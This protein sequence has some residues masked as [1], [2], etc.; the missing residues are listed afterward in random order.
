MFS[1][2][3][4]GP[5]VTPGNARPAVT[6]FAQQL[7]DGAESRLPVELRPLAE[8]HWRAFREHLPRLPHDGT[9]TWLAAL[10]KLFAC[11]DFVARTCAQHPDLLGELIESRD[12]LRAYETGELTRR[13]ARALTGAPDE[14]ALKMRLRQLR[15]REMLR[16]AIRDLAGWA[17]LP[18]VLVTLSELADSCIDAA[19][20]WLSHG[21]QEEFG[22]P[23]G[24]DGAPVGLVVLG[25]GKLGGHELNFSSDV[26]LILTYSE[27]GETSGGRRSLSHGEFFVRL[28]QSL[29]RV[30]SEPTAD[31]FVFRVDT[32]LRPFGSSGPLALSFDAMEHYYQAHGREWERYALIKARAS[33]GDR[34]AGEELLARLRPFVYRRYLDYGA[35]EAIRGMKEMI[36]REVERK[37]MAD[38]VKLGP[39]GIREIEFIAQALQLIRGGR[40]PAL[41]ERTTLKALSLLAAA[42]H[43]EQAAVQTLSKAYHF[44]RRTEHCIQMIADQQTHNLPREPLDRARVAIAMGFADWE[45]FHAA[46]ARERALVQSQ[47]TGLLG[48]V[49]KP[50]NETDAFAVLWSGGMDKDHAVPILAHAGYQDAERVYAF[51]SELRESSA[52]QA[53]STEGRA[54]V[55]KFIP[56]LLRET[57]SAPEPDV[58]I[59]RLIQLCEAIGR[60]TAYFSLLIE[61]P[62]ALTQLINLAAASPWIAGWISQHPVLLD[63]LLDPRGLYELPDRTVLEA[64]LKAR[65]ESLAPDDLEAQMEVMREFRHAH[66][67]RIAAADIGP[68]LPSDQVG[69]RL[70]QLAE[71]LIAACLDL[72]F[73]LMTERHGSPGATAQSPAPGFVV[74][75]YGKLGSLEL[76]YA[77]DLDMIFLYDE[78]EGG[79]TTGARPIPNELF[80]ARLGQRLINLLTTRTPAGILYQVDMRLRPSGNAGPLVTSLTA[81][82]RYQ[83]NQAWT[84]EHQALVRAR[85]IAGAPSLRDAFETA[86]R[87]VLSRHRDE[88]ALRAEVKDMRNRMA[89]AHPPQEDGFDVKHD[90]GGIVDI[91]FMVQYWV[92]AWA[93]AHPDVT[94]PRDNIHIME[95]LATRGLIPRDWADALAQ[96]YRRC[97]SVE[98]RLKLMERG[99]RVPRA[100]FESTAATVLTIWNEI[101]ERE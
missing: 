9:E 7:F 44:L 89:A 6:D 51:L 4:I 39:G 5:I 16:I 66:M 31:G 19:L 85:P 12:L 56:L 35:L 91:E 40:E 95:A 49:E 63:E 75:G 27:E 57:A 82:Q 53:L 64:E 45:S 25:L 42:E 90:R 72:S 62:H 98:Q 46:L 50:A 21:M 71:V 2:K 96:A 1:A 14:H 99:A 8:A 92:L 43:L 65:L 87:E 48:M 81:F 88:S 47:F 58:T 100:E 83:Q 23:R 33:A 30:L 67:L 74:I 11:S 73:R 20:A 101:F 59:S 32:R 28:S 37:S 18:E 94:Q 36:A 61:N 17:D 77:S 80:F 84:W 15:R 38:N 10:P 93:H 70:A 78:T 41:R 26:D 76:G 3:I 68:G 79:M 13:V 60:R 86:R 69:M 97:L 34:A 29:I 22:I 55:D 52:Y 54:R 24:S